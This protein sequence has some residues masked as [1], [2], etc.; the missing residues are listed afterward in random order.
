MEL[1]SDS[2]A[3][4]I[5]LN[6]MNTVKLSKLEAL[7]GCDPGD[8]YLLAKELSFRAMAWSENRPFPTIPFFKTLYFKINEDEFIESVWAHE[9]H[10]E[11]D[12]V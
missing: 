7:K 12:V 3:G 1:L 5:N 11:F 2:S 4:A 8:V 9:D 6:I 10:I